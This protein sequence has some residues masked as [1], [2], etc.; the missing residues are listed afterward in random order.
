M[1]SHPLAGTVP[2]SGDPDADAELAAGLLGSAKERHEHRVVVDA[3]AA[4]LA[5]CATAGRARRP[6]HRPAPQRV[7]PGTLIRARSRPGRPSL[8]SSWPPGCTPP[9]PSPAR[10]GRPRWPTSRAV[11]GFDRGRYAGPVGWV[12]AAGDGEWAVGI[13]SRHPRRQPGP[14]VAGVGVVADSDPEAELAET[15]LKLQAL[16][17]AVVRP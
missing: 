17:A 6:A 14:L 1:R 12:D 13:R 10:R 4:V 11:E 3:V 9:R 15:Q 7:P 16:L 8:P 2:R 5:R